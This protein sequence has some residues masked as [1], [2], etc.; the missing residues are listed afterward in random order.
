VIALLEL[1]GAVSS[2]ARVPPLWR[3]DMLWD[4]GAVGI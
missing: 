1:M 4:V 3:I 2:E